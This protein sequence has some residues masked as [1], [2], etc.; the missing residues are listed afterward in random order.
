QRLSASF[1]GR[2]VF[3]PVAAWIARGDAP[4]EVFQELPRLQV[5]LRPDDLAEIIYIDHYGNAVT[6]LRAA[7]VP[8]SATLA[9]RA[10]RLARAKVCADVP[11]G[12]AFWYENSNG[13][14][15]IAANGASAAALLNIAIGD[16]VKV[17]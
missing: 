13:L 11:P 14:V 3:A 15:E 7:R 8:K 4:P 10:A 16:P 1:H 2:D 6:G 9:A 5:R 12:S 17:M